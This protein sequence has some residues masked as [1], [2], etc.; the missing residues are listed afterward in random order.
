MDYKNISKNV[1][2][3][4]LLVRRFRKERRSR[5]HLDDRLEIE[6]KRR[7]QL[8]DALKNAGASEELRRINENYSYVDNKSNVQKTSSPSSSS[9]NQRSTPNP[10]ERTQTPQERPERMKQEPMN[11]PP[12]SYPQPMRDP[13]PPP[14][15]MDTKPWCYSGI[16]LMNN[17]AAFWQSYSDSLAQELEIERKN[18]QQHMEREDKSPLQDRSAYYKNSVLFTSSAT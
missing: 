9:Q 15:Q 3:L 6:R 13:P 16:D 1:I 7:T 18:R 8:E 12:L 14:H 4:E 17:G 5:R 11:T 2:D 10:P